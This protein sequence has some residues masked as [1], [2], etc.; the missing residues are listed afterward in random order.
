M[1]SLFFGREESRD[2]KVANEM[3]PP[4]LI[5]LYVASSS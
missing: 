5:L 1:I 4:S 3:D 2:W